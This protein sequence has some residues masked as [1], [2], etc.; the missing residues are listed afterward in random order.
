ME[1]NEERTKGSITGTNATGRGKTANVRNTSDH[2]DVT[3]RH[4][5]VLPPSWGEEND[6][7]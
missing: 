5:V 6:K 7:F 1:E 4:T 2:D 3:L